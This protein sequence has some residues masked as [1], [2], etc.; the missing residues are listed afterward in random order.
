MAS[1]VWQSAGTATAG[2]SDTV[3]VTAPTGI[4]DGNILLAVIYAEPGTQTISPPTGFTSIL[5][6]ASGASEDFC[7][8][9]FWKRASGESGNYAF[10]E[11]GNTWGNG[12]IHRISGAIASGSPIDAIGAGDTA[13]GSNPTL[14]GITT[15]STDTLLLYTLANFDG[16]AGTA[17]SGMTERADSSGRYLADLAIAA[18]AATGNKQATFASDTWVGVL[19]AIAS[20]AASGGRTT[21][22]TRSSWLGMELGMDWR[23]DEL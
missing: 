9:W 10:T 6:K 7:V 20:Q 14:T 19:I 15:L 13:V 8:E 18:P 23:H 16:G 11:T 1:P 2:N 4:A 17:P 22:N 5:K 21:K 3:T 12:I